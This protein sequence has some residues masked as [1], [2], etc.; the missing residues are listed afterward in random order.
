[1][2]KLSIIILIINLST[3]MFAGDVSTFMNLGFSP[4]GK[5]FLFGEYGIVSDYQ[6]AY[7]NMWLVDV[8][9]NSF[10]SGGVFSGEYKT[11][12]EPGESAIGGLLKLLNE[13]QKK[14]EAYKID[15][16]EQGRPLYVRINDDNNVDKLKFRDFVTGL[17]YEFVMDKKIREQGSNKYSSFGISLKT[18]DKSGKVKS[19]KLGNP[20]YERKSVIDYKIERILHSS[21]GDNIVVVLSKYILD[22]ENTIIRYMVETISLK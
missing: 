18:T 5:Y 19:Y 12:I 3:F 2:K 7:S 21:T 9:K 13:A 4:D 15:F 20:A 17:E 22:G 1:M 8:K 11:V 10:V 14:V 16:L 6:K